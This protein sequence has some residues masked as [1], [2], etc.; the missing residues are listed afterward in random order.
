MINIP[1]IADQRLENERLTHPTFT[2]PVEV[3]RW[4]GA[5]QAQE[6]ALAKWGLSMRMQNINGAPLTDAAFEK[7]FNEG[8]ILRT[9]VMRPTWHFVTPEDIR[10][11]LELT[12]PRV[13]TVNGYM[14]RQAGLD[15]PLLRRACEVITRALEGGKELTKT[16]LGAALAE[17]GI[18]YT[19]MN[20]GYVIHY[21]ELERVVCS[22]ARR[23]KQFTYA[24]IDERAPQ[25]KSLP[26]DEALATLTQRFFTSHGPATVHDF[27]WWSGLTIVD[28]KAGLEMCAG[29]LTSFEFNGKTWWRAA[30]T[31][32]PASQPV[33]PTAWLLPP[34]DEYTIAY[35]DH[36]PILDEQY[37][38]TAVEAIFNGVM[39]LDGKLVGNWRRSFPN[40]KTVLVEYAPFRDLNDEEQAAFATTANRFANFLE[41]SLDLVYVNPDEMIRWRKPEKTTGTGDE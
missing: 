16:E 41:L 3:V 26:R 4:F 10:W 31:E 5:V 29:T 38:E 23:G 14:Y 7:A 18:V 12:A 17:N 2:Q 36:S 8:Q 20:L 1:T 9:H 27:A 15:E 25:A 13:H 35:R 40:K 28:V 32:Y 22:G 37:H 30:D 24:L 19:G 6:Y 34:Y 39:M 11:I 21:A 33:T